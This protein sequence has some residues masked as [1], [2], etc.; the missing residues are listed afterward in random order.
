MNDLHKEKRNGLSV[1]YLKDVLLRKR[2]GKKKFQTPGFGLAAQ[3]FA[4]MCKFIIKKLGPEEGEALIKEA[5]EYFG[6]K[7]GQSIAHNVQE[8]GKPLSFKNWLIFTDIHGSNFTAKPYIDKDDLVAPVSS[9]AFNSAAREWGL[10]EYSKLYCKY[11]DFAILEGYNPDV[12]LELEQRH[13]S[14]KDH[15][16]FRYVMKEENKQGAEK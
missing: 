14:G 7:R 2:I 12:K 15:C 8:M 3:L 1:W 13:A 6:K 16:L 9:C 5:V 10:E 11:A 4:V